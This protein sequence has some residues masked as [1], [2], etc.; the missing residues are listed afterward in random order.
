MIGAVP[1]SFSRNKVFL[2]LTALEEWLRMV[3]TMVCCRQ[4][5]V[6]SCQTYVCSCQTYVCC[7]QTIV[8]L[9]Q[10]KVALG[11]VFANSTGRA[12]FGGF[13]AYFRC[14]Y[15]HIPHF[16][17]GDLQYC[18][19]YIKEAFLKKKAKKWKF[20]QYVIKKLSLFCL[21]KNLCVCLRH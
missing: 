4:T 21:Y 7:R 8:C 9:G 13:I 11:F 2:C 18:R 1:L 3:V 14:F 10:T 6:C 5:I 12:I 15:S 17:N 16:P 20:A 19:T